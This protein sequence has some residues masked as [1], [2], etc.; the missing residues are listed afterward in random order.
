ME[1]MWEDRRE[2][3]KNIWVRINIKDMLIQGDEIWKL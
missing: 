3:V 1:D 2:N